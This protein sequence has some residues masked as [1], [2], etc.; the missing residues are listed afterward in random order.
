MKKEATLSMW[1]PLKNKA[2]AVLFVATVISNIGTWMHEV[3]A[4]WKMTQ[5]TQDPTMVA[6]IQTAVSLPIFFFALPAGAIADLFNRKSLLLTIN[7]IALMLAGALAILMQLDSVTPYVLLLCTFL[8]GVCAA[9]IAPAWQAIVPGL[10]PKNAL[11]SAV[12][13]NG[14]GINISR[15]IGPALA[16]VLIVS[17]GI[18]SPFWVNCLSFIVII[19]ALYWWKPTD[20]PQSGLPKEHILPAMISGLKY[21]KHSAPLKATLI[22]A[23]AFFIAASAF[24]SLLPIIVSK[25]L[26]AQ[27]NIFGI[28]TGLVGVGALFGALLLPKLKAKF[29]PSKLL[30]VA[31]VTDALLF[32]LLALTF[33]VWVLFV[34]CFA[35]G[36][37]WIIALANLNVSAQTSLPNWV[38]ARGLA[39][40]L[41]VFFGTMS[42]GSI[43]WGNIAS[44]FTLQTTLYT[45][46][47]VLVIGSLITVKF[48]LNLGSERDLEPALHWPTPTTDEALLDKDIAQDLAPV[49]ITIEYTVE[50]KNWPSFVDAIQVLGEARKRNGAYQWGVMQDTAEPRQF[51][52]YFFE[53]SWLQH[54]HHHER[55]SG[56]DKKHQQF[57]NEFHCGDLPP[58]VKHLVG[59]KRSVIHANV[60]SV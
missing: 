59:A 7:V 47:A 4:S 11:S 9:F 25:G 51:T 24:W 58:K 16:G 29:H 36:S 19:L 45:A 32:T 26:N 10:V 49:L 27:A 40:F 50:Q 13:L 42:I 34:I 8:L 60:S 53:H 23:G 31:S 35:F 1:S 14:V 12:S 38:R 3:G 44:L 41:T 18:Q 20:Q 46:S 22:R 33:N 55:T 43:L 57:V 52:E 2:Y 21:A 17:F 30:F 39:I 56:D 6:L 28:A 37:M 5:M 48:K 15:A 54:L